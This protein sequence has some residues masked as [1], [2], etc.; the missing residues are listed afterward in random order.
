MERT[1]LVIGPSAEKGAGAVEFLISIPVVLLLILGTLQASLLYQARLQ[2]EVAAQEAARA[3]ALHGGNM[4]AM[5]EGLARGLTPLYTHGQDVRALLAGRARAELAARQAQI[6]ILSP[7]LEAFHDHKEFGRLPLD[8]DTGNKKLTPDGNWGWGIPESHLG[9]RSTELK[10]E[11]GISVQDANLLK[12]R[13]TYHAPLIMPFIDRLLARFDGNNEGRGSVVGS[14]KGG[15]GVFANQSGSDPIPDINHSHLPTF[16]LTA[17]ATFRMQTPFTNVQALQKVAN[18]QTPRTGGNE[19]YTPP[20]RPDLDPL[21]DYAPPADSE[22]QQPEDP[23]KPK[24]EDIMSCK[25]EPE[26]SGGSA[27]TAAG[28]K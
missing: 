2:L 4:A 26:S 28:A 25:A 5:R 23:E 9:Y 19:D 20:E 1:Y 7:T 27:P 24:A 16:P 15:Q 10:K 14:P 18:L 3:G 13:V 12:I 22:Q 21:Q 11:S 6:E 8:D 17:E